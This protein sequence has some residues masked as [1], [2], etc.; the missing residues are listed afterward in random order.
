MLLLVVDCC[1]PLLLWQACN[2]L[3]V[4]NN[5]ETYPKVVMVCNSQLLAIT[6]SYLLLMSKS[7]LSIN[8]PTLHLQILLS[9]NSHLSLFNH[10]PLS[11]IHPLSHNHSLLSLPN[12]LFLN[13]PLL[14]LVHHLFI[15]KWLVQQHP[16][17]LVLV[18]GSH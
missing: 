13:H 2:Q 14:C 6:P 7:L 8:Q 17:V 18:V 12:L 15:Q 1:T 4:L 11:L 3:L 16:K 10:Q 9:L 5:L